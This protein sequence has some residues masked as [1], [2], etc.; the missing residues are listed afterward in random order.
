MAALAA[1]VY[2]AFLSPEDTGPLTGIDVY[3]PLEQPPP[4]ERGGDDA[5]GDGRDRSRR[6]ADSAGPPGV[7]VAPPTQPPTGVVP[8][9]P[10]ESQYSGTV[11]RI[12]ERVAQA[13]R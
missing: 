5:D 7:A 9:T 1:I 11:A 10:T 12:L 2:L 4:P 3:P 6:P 8:D 13:R